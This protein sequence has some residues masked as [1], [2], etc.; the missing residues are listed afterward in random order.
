MVPA[1]GDW[2]LLA[3]AGYN[4]LPPMKAFLSLRWV[5]G[6]TPQYRL[7]KISLMMALYAG[8]AADK[9]LD[10]AAS[11][12]SGP[13]WKKQEPD[14]PFHFVTQGMKE[15]EKPAALGPDSAGARDSLNYYWFQ[16]ER[17][18]TQHVSG[19]SL[20]TYWWGGWGVESTWHQPS[21]GGTPG[22]S[23]GDVQSPG[24][25]S[26]GIFNWGWVGSKF[27][28]CWSVH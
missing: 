17:K 28:P 11:I 8:R 5:F 22:R 6:E 7:V 18:A 21:L 9:W 27:S 10:P 12:R 13:S 1:K 19:S 3:S 26:A 24:G 15:A 25:P 2:I 23:A 16:W 4:S 14:R 20:S